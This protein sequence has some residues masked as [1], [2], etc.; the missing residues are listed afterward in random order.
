MSS[1]LPLNTVGSLFFSFLSFFF[2]YRFLS[3]G[4]GDNRSLIHM[5]SINSAQQPWVT[6]Q[7]YLTGMLREGKSTVHMSYIPAQCLGSILYMYIHIEL[8]CTVPT[9]GGL[10]A[11]V[12]NQ[13]MYM[14]RPVIMAGYL[15]V[16]WACWQWTG[17]LTSGPTSR[18]VG[19]VIRAR[20]SW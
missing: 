2:F 20:P 9:Y 11:C 7:A 10:M 14:F 17:Q 3:C 1:V 12:C 13:V 5:Y 4:G 6:F 15:Q 19:P 8:S 18:L 16:G